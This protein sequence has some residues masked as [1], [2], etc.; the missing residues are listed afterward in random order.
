MD[1]NCPLTGTCVSPGLRR[2][3][4]TGNVPC[5]T[6]YPLKSCKTIGVRGHVSR[7]WTTSN[8]P[9]STRSRMRLENGR[10]RG[11]SR[12]YRPMRHRHTAWRI[13][14][15]CH[16]ALDGLGDHHPFPRPRAPLRVI[17]RCRVLHASRRSRWP[18]LPLR[19]HCPLQ[20]R[21]CRD[22]PRHRFHPPWTCPPD[23][24][25]RRGRTTPRQR[26]SWPRLSHNAYPN[27]AL[28]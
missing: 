4:S 9:T 27:Q 2:K 1:T 3:H 17:R 18:Q 23:L 28:G 26:S 19:I 12:M 15:Q 11:V 6:R 22:M 16:R 5:R 21:T 10:S 7:A 24:S 25:H 8:R 13:R 20:A 14:L